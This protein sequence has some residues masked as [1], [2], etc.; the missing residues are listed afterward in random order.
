M[1]V[2]TS[3]FKLPLGTPLPEF[4]LPDHEGKL[5]RLAELRGEGVLVV[6][7]SCNHC[8]F[9]THV[10]GHLGALAATFA[11]ADVQFVA[12]CSNDITEYPDDDIPGLIDQRSRASWDFPYLIDANQ[13]AALTLG[14]ACTPDFFVFD[15]GGRLAYRGAYDHSTP[16]NGLTLTGELL[17]AALQL[18][19]ADRPVPEPHKPA[20][21]CGIKWLTANE[22]S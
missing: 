8:P 11:E 18:L 7:F 17:Q 13:S 10:E 12:I 15:R 14:A 5:V 22:P 21:G 6:V 3:T 20:M 19:L 9:V 16:G 4:E 2:E 1:A